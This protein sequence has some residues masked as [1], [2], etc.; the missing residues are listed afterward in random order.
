MLKIGI[1]GAK[2]SA[3]EK[4]CRF[5]CEQKGVNSYEIFYL[6]TTEKVLKALNQGK[7]DWG[8]F[9]MKSSR[10][11]LVAETQK[12]IQSFCF[13]KLAEIDLAIEH[14]LLAN[15]LKQNCFYQKIISHPQALLEHRDY[16]QKT[17]PQAE[18][19]SADDTAL[20][21]QKLGAGE[22]GEDVL[23]IALKE[24]AQL[25]GLMLKEEKLPTNQGYVTTFYLVD[26]ASVL[27]N[28]LK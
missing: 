21:A 7:I 12:A 5:F 4:A 20:A 23:V 24:C 18:L 6:I 19:V 15:V 1:Q 3:N 16:L 11:G 13:N 14:V 22:Y 9:A 8:V 17:Y 27:E 25:Y 28:V 10:G 2:G 26:N